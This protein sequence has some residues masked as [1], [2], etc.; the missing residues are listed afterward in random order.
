MRTLRIFVSSPGDVAEE[1]VLTRRVIERVSA[2][3]SGWARLEPVFWEHEPLRASAGFQEQIVA[4]AD[5][6]IVVMILWSRLGT[7]LPAQITRPDGSRYDSGTEFEF[8]NAI[9]SHRTKGLPDLLVYRKMAR[10]VAPL[11]SR[12]ELLDRLRQK[13]ALDA[14][15]ERWFRDDEGSFTAAFHPFERQTEFEELLETHLRKLVDARIGDD[16]VAATQRTQRVEWTA[17]SPFRGLE[18]FQGEH[19]PV[20][21][22]RTAATSDVLNALRKQDAEGRPFVLILGMSGCG[23]SSLVRAG[24]LPILTQP[25]VIEGVALWRTALLRP[26]DAG[27]DLFA[28]LAASLT[29]EGALPELAADGTGTDEL[30]RM[31]RESP[32]AAAPLIKGGLSQV[33]AELA[34]DEGLERQPRVRLALLVDQLEEIFTAQG[35]TDEDRLRFV[36]ALDALVRSRRVWVLATLRSDFY[37]RCAELHPL[38]ALKEGAGQYD[39]LPPTHAENGQMI[40][41]PAQLAGLDFEENEQ[42]GERLDD[43]LRDAA[44]RNPEAL[45]LLQF[46]L[47]ELYKQRDET[48]RLTLAAYGELG[49]VEGALAQRA[50]SVFARLEPPIQETFPQVMSSLITVD[51]GET[52][53]VTRRRAPLGSFPAGS[54]ARKLVDAYVESRLLVTDRD[55]RGGAVVSVAHEALIEHWPR[56]QN[57]LQHNRELLRV[58][59]RIAAAAERWEGESRSSG[60]LLAS[61]K[62]LA[63]AE[64]LLRA[65]DV[66]LPE[67]ERQF[68]T[69]SLA[70]GRRARW[71][72]RSAIAALFFLAV[73]AAGAAY[74]ANDRRAEAVTAREESEAVT[75]FLSNMLGS[76]NPQ[77][78]GRDVLVRDV[79]DEAS[80]SVEEDLAGQPLIQARLM[81]TMGDTYRELG[82]YEPA[83]SLL[84]RTRSI[85]VEHLGENDVLVGDSLQAL[86]NLSY[87]EGEYK[88]AQSLYERALEIQ[89]NALGPE[90]PAVASTL[91]NLADLCVTMGDYERAVETHRKALEIRESALRPDHPD[92]ADTLSNLALALQE[93]GA[94]DEARPLHERAIEILE[95]AHGPEHVALANPLSNLAILNAITG[96]HEAARPLFERALETREKA[97]GPDHPAVGRDL[98]NL[99]IHHASLGEFDAARPLFERGLAVKEK[100]LGPEHPSVVNALSNLAAFLVDTGHT[101]D[102]L[103]LLEKVVRLRE[104]TLGSEH[105]QVATDL[106]N[107]GEIL[108]NIEEYDEARLHFQ[109]ALVIHEKTRGPDHADTARS[110]YLLGDLHR[111]QG[112]RQEA[113]PLLER[114]LTIQEAALGPENPTLTGTL[115]SLAGLFQAAGESQESLQTL[116]RALAI[117]ENTLGPDHPNIAMI[118][119]NRGELLKNTG[120]YGKARLC[121]DRALAIR[122]RTKGPDHRSALLNIYNIACVCAREGKNEEALEH[123]Q[124]AVERGFDGA[125]MADDTDLASLHG[126]PEFETLVARVTERNGR[127]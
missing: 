23:K 103:P 108:A 75:G 31:L 15:L 59:G 124:L 26:G 32:E 52:E 87:E 63:E 49:G 66:D 74:V 11:D 104:K 1:R 88:Q 97:L 77:E 67:T 79:L 51:V 102:A 28:S 44:S 125:F 92:L 25:G 21:F 64:E 126:D 96:N 117:N 73:L 72:K 109:H 83:G 62:S 47:E 13:E 40:R 5:C 46:T 86:A 65:R 35:V 118:E 8:E 76:V 115:I 61:G 18:V 80:K 17:G 6:D 27:S 95:A 119:E 123:L 111:L 90:H 99:A 100:T 42:T 9:E 121:F 16:A 68:V 85:L 60:S 110:L 48:G 69:A 29:R 2:V 94:Y 106:E 71:L 33:A 127:N 112:E 101:E 120:E 20:F 12:A 81:Y 37:A 89:E 10:P 93:T 57:W 116:D 4:P 50:E 7:R 113:R 55:D 53:T 38:R 54:P 70:R 82:L 34:R 43:L 114:A 39:L 22:G 84:D 3:T 78:I 24:V 30:A 107:L 58:R 98:E 122:E 91:N 36:A 41:R 45:P 56:L 19:A 14:F 105:P